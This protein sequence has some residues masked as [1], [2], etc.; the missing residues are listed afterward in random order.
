VHIVVNTR[1]LL[2]NKLDGIGWFSHE[3]LS[4][5]TKDLPD[6]RFT[7]LFDR[8]FDE[9]FIY[10]PNVEGK[11]VYPPARHPLL[12]QLYFQR[13]I[14]PKLKGLKADLFF[15]PDG[16]LSPRT[17]VPQV[18]VIHDLNFEHRPQDLPKAYRKYYRHYFPRFAKKAEHIITVS[19][20]SAQ[21]ICDTYGIARDKISVAHNGYNPA[22]KPLSEEEKSTAKTSFANGRPYFIFVGNFSYRKNI[23]GIIR[24]YD[25]YRKQGGEHALVLVGNPLWK[26][27]EMEQAL[28]ES[29][30][31]ADIHFSGR[32]DIDD[33]VMAMG[34]AE[35]L[36]FP[37]YFEGFG[38]PVLEAYAA[39]IP[40]I[41]SNNTSLPEVAGAG[42]ILCSPDDH[43]KISSAMRNI[44]SDDN[45]RL[46]LIQEGKKQIISFSWEQTANKVKEAL[47][48][49]ATR[50]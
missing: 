33:L 18:P 14:P 48:H 35:A 24:S 28:S 19:E 27:A 12:Y 43:E 41:T 47:F 5:L 25:L 8:P 10:G 37:S 13:S 15:S 26:Y 45:Q 46:T 4:R 7:F 31:Q 1:L 39:G 21:D 34:G 9:R 17:S 42:S 3:V 40:V 20:Y 23:H 49:I 30:N 44:E 6:W 50:N 29:P 11:V 22:Y 2:P 36:L 38:I 16:F 32:L